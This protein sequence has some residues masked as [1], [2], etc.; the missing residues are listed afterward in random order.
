MLQ[1][2]F[3]SAASPYPCTACCFPGN[4][5]RYR[6]LTRA[7]DTAGASY[8]VEVLCR[9]AVAGFSAELPCS[10]PGHVH[11]AQDETVSVSA[12]RLG[13]VKGQQRGLLQAGDSLL[14]EK[15]EQLV[16]VGCQQCCSWCKLHL[17]AVGARGEMQEQLAFDGWLRTSKSQGAQQHSSPCM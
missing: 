16:Y 2:A 9:K 13:W 17:A 6:V 7:A 8:S 10:L 1:H 4:G 12:G 3:L 15:G 5:T 14:I 11:L